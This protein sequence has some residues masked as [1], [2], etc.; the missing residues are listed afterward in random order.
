[1]A[2][3][4]FSYYKAETDRFQDIKIKR[5]KKKYRC[6]GYAVYQYVLNEIYRV[7]GYF[8]RFTEDELFDASEYWGLEEEEVT[9]IVDYCA[10]IGLFDARLWRDHGVLTA[11]SIQ[12]RY[13]DI[14]KVCKKPPVIEEDLRL[15]EAEKAAPA[16]PPVP[17]LFPP[18]ELPVLRVVPKAKPEPEPEASGKLREPSG[19][20][21]E[22]PG[23]SGKCGA[24]SPRRDEAEAV[25][26]SEG[27][28]EGVSGK[29]QKFPEISGNF[30]ENSDKEKKSYK[31]ENNP[32]QT[33]PTE[34]AA[35]ASPKGD[36]ER[37]R[38]V[39]RAMSVPPD[40]ARWLSTI[41][42]I[43]TDTSPL[44][45]LVEEVRRSGGRLTVGTYLLPSLRALVAAGR[46]KT[47]PKEA[48]EREELR[49]QLRQIRVASYDIP[50]IL[51]AA[52]GQERV[53]REAIDEVR[54]SK[55]RLTMPARYLLSK[56][57]KP[58]KRKAS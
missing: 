58:E 56:L 12:S 51:A 54:R 32:P 30:P 40:D 28:V 49:R 5:L 46:L 34:E 43:D 7:R 9:A 18:E 17:L 36:P 15:V 42:G 19:N 21:A 4:G 52:E 53:L 14:C 41:E 26:P 55:G 47:R 6:A 48:D 31:A 39:L 20:A 13:I 23:P 45:G 37:L 22:V 3:A 10:E 24:S 1:M 50:G 27:I 44:W 57:R 11:R 29:F 8:L 25:P 35:K 16:P 33:P 38:A 2:K